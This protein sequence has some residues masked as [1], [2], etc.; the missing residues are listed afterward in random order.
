MRIMKE[1]NFY[2]RCSHSKT[3]TCTIKITLSSIRHGGVRVLTGFSTSSAPPTTRFETQLCTFVFLGGDGYIYEFTLKHRLLIVLHTFL[4]LFFIHFRRNSCIM[5]TELLRMVQYSQ[6]FFDRLL[7][8]PSK[9]KTKS[10]HYS[11]VTTAP[12]SVGGW[13]FSRVLDFSLSPQC[14]GNTRGLSHIGKHGSH[15]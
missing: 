5:Q 4:F 1:T 9:A 10:I 11:F 15:I 6:H 7:G 3:I 2:P 12:S 14:Q 13:R 8:H